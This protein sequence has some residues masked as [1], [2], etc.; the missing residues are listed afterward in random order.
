MYLSSNMKRNLIIGG[1]ALLAL[2]VVGSVVGTIISLIVILFRG[3]IG[4]IGFAFESIFNLFL[5]GVL[6]Y[7]IALDDIVGF[8]LSTYLDIAQTV[9]A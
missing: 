4:L 1:L 2:I 5:V 7:L 9:I 6:G 3:I 8:L